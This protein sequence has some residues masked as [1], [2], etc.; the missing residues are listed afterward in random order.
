MGLVI[1]SITKL[2]LVSL[3]DMVALKRSHCFLHYL[4]EHRHTKDAPLYS[5]HAL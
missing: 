4:P 3:D 2:L 1:I 5:G